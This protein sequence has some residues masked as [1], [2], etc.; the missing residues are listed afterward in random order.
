MPVKTSVL[1]VLIIS[2]VTC[3]CFKQPAVVVGA[4]V[5]NVDGVW[6]QKE[7]GSLSCEPDRAVSLEAARAEL[8][9]N[10]VKVLAQQKGNDGQ[11]HIQMCGAPTG[12]LNLIQ[13]SKDDVSKAKE[14][15][16]LETK[17]PGKK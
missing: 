12:N 3:A 15:G 1:L 8:E 16:F 4:Q 10:D 9:K 14:L 11:M 17:N 2:F 6:L 7:D 5:N 13:V